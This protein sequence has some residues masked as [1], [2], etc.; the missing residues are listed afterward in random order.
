MPVSSDARTQNKKPHC[1]NGPSKPAKRRNRSSEEL[2]RVWLSVVSVRNVRS[3][4]F[5]TNKKMS[6]SEK[7]MKASGL[8][9][10]LALYIQN[11][12]KYIFTEIR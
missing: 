11:L 8:C 9:V 10:L 3:T 4:K 6:E 7:P 12:E 2:Q 1:P 5:V